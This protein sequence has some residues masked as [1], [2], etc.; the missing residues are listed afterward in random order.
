MDGWMDGCA[1]RLAIHWN[2]RE[3]LIILLLL[4]LLRAARLKRLLKETSHLLDSTRAMT[5][6]DPFCSPRRGSNEWNEELLPPSPHRQRTPKVLYCW[7]PRDNVSVGAGAGFSRRWSLRK[8]PRQVRL[9]LRR[10]FDARIAVEEDSS[11][12]EEEKKTFALSQK[13]TKK[14]QRGANEKEK[15]IN[16]NIV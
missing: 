5:C 7:K 3:D 1:T 10:R 8:D 15:N 13:T 9:F 16:R 6:K 4:L 11:R 2:V 14:R 12:K